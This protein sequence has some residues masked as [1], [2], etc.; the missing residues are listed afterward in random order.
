MFKELFNFLKKYGLIELY[1]SRKFV[2]IQV[3]FQMLYYRK[4]K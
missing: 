1:R 2:K 3:N 4:S